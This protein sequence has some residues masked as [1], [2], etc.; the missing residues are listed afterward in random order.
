MSAPILAPDDGVVTYYIDPT[1]G[2]SF[3]MRFDDGSRSYGTHLSKYAFGVDLK[4]DTRS[5]PRRV[6][7]GDIIGYVGTGGNAS[8]TPPHLH[9]Q[10]WLPDGTLVDPYPYLRAAEQRYAPK[11]IGSF[12]PALIAGAIILTSAGAAAYIVRRRRA[13]ALARPPVRPATQVR[14]RRPLA[15]APVRG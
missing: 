9:F 15:V 1:G 14:H 4:A 5:S 2:P 7:A 3:G 10:Y 11:T 6:S 13:Q 12:V 8:G